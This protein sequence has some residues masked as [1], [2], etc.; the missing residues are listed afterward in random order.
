MLKHKGMFSGLAAWRG[1]PQTGNAH[2]RPALACAA[3][4]QIAALALRAMGLPRLLHEVGVS[5]QASTH[6]FAAGAWGLVPG[7]CGG[8][9]ARG[10]AD[11]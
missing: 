6:L 5:V 11:R 3:A 10:C 8:A 4:L 1:G 9:I 7:A 2:A